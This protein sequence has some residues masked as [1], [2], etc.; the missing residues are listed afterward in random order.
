MD[1]FVLVCF[2]CALF[3]WV[4]AGL[5]N[6]VASHFYNQAANSILSYTQDYDVAITLAGSNKELIKIIKKRLKNV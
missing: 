6:L 2:L 1:K 4:F 3:L 5:A